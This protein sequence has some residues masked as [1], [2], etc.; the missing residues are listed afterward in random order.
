[1]KEKLRRFIKS[2]SR[3][4]Y[5]LAMLLAA[6]LLIPQALATQGEVTRRVAVTSLGID[7]VAEGY[8]VTAQFSM[9]G[10]GGEQGAE[11]AGSASAAG[12][13]LRTAAEAISIRLGRT[14]DLSFCAAVFIGEDT[15]KEGAGDV[16][17]Y[18]LRTGAMDGD[19]LALVAKGT[20]KETMDLISKV[21]KTAAADMP[22]FLRR[23]NRAGLAAAVSVKDF[24]ERN[25]D[26]G[27][28]VLPM[29]EVKKKEPGGKNGGESGGEKGEGGGGESGETGGG[30]AAGA[31]FGDFTTA[32]FKGG[33]MIRALDKD[34]TRAFL[35]LDKRAGRA[36]VYLEGVTA[37]GLQDG[38]AAVELKSKTVK[39][40]TRF[41]NGKPVAELRLKLKAAVNELRAGDM[42]D[43]F[44][45]PDKKALAGVIGAKLGELAAADVRNLWKTAADEQ[46]D[47]LSVEDMFRRR[48]PKEY[49]TWKAANPD[50][51]FFGAAEL[52]VNVTGAEIVL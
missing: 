41:E 52:R 10:G 40:K 28:A 20:A 44:P 39:L 38:A 12:K 22:E 25:K 15:A 45:P 13:S 11:S 16:L 17:D 33:R 9:P 50:A 19:A 3:R 7:R 6:V 34:E 49:R 37:G 42:P 48:R 32:V 47:F 23:S 21:G 1:M 4:K 2:L 46:C 26:A 35:W 27:A 43:F 5:I 24:V 30:E 14:A 29:A 18:F 31:E 51:P 36:A 8:E